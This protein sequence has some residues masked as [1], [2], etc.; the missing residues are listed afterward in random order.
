MKRRRF[1]LAVALLAVLG[2][3]SA[4]HLLNKAQAQSDGSGDRKISKHR[5]HKDSDDDEDSSADDPDGFNGSFRETNPQRGGA[6]TTGGTTSTSAI[7]YHNGPVMRTP[8]VY[9]IWYGN[10]NQANGS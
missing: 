9:I 2:L 7:L 4:S 5:L 10:W 1:T 6:L 8:V 3:V